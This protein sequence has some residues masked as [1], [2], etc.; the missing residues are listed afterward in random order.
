[1]E[2]QNKQIKE[3]KDIN[4]AGIDDVISQD[5][6]LSGERTNERVNDEWIL[7]NEWQMHDEPSS[8]KDL[9]LEINCLSGE[10]TKWR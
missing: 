7:K 2:L 5:E 4:E 3:L 8:K 9:A 6:L 10:W 1:M